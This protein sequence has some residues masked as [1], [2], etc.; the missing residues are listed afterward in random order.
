MEITLH[1]RDTLHWWEYILSATKQAC[2]A[3]TND[4]KAHCFN[5]HI[6]RREHEHKMTQVQPKLITNVGI[7]LN[8]H[9]LH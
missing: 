6:L 3:F 8:Y 9:T 4:F 2:G 7:R 1:S 5:W